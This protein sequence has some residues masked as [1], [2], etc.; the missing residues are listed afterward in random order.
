VIVNP[1]FGNPI[2]F[3]NYIEMKGVLFK[4]RR[5]VGYRIQE[6]VLAEVG[7]KNIVNWIEQF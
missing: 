2:R 6:L 7:E 4:H 1:W 3:P 5:D